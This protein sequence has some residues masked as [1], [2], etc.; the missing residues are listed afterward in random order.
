[1]KSDIDRLKSDVLDIKETAKEHAKEQ[2]KDM[3]SMR[4]SHTETRIYIRQI[5]DSQT[6]MAKET[7]ESQLALAKETKENQIAVM[8]A[9]TEIKEEPA[10]NAKL[11]KV[12]GIT[13][14]IT[15]ILGSVLGLVKMF[16]PNLM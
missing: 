11:Y 9:I 5:Q 12:A 15:Y 8:Q 6:L 7:K 1:M 16:A 13:F 14:L 2:N 10:K 3:L 4:D